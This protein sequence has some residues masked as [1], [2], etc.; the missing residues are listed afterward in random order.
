MADGACLGAVQANAI[1]SPFAFLFFWA[2]DS[3]VGFILNGLAS[4]LAWLTWWRVYN[5][6]AVVNYEE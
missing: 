1:V 5:F 2:F 4:V 3:P 6:A